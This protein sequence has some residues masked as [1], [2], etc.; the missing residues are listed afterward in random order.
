MTLYRVVLTNSL[1]Y[2][3]F[4]FS[5]KDVLRRINKFHKMNKGVKYEE[6]HIRMCRKLKHERHGILYFSNGWPGT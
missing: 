1:N 2:V 4:A 3:M 5:R 6:K